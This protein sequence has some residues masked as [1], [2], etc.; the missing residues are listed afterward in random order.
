MLGRQITVYLGR[1]DQAPFEQ[2]LSVAA[3]FAILKS[4]SSSTRPE[5]VSTTAISEY[6][7]DRLRVLLA[8]PGDLDAISFS[9][10]L[11]RPEYS[12]DPTHQP[13]IEFDRSYVGDAV[14]RAGRLYFVPRYYDQVGRVVSKPKEFLDWA[15]RLLKAAQDAT[16]EIRQ[17]I[18]CGAEA[19]ALSKAGT[20]L[21]S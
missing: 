3:D 5:L 2:A 10:V 21:E 17:G 1:S 8:R 7:K 4:R 9:Q 6:G 16:H 15:E 18:Y 14:I 12:C 20:R 19:L 11:G 13:I